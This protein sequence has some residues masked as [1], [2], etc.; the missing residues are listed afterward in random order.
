MSLRAR[1][2]TYRAA[3]ET[4][5][6]ATSSAADFRRKAQFVDYDGLR[7]A[8]ESWRADHPGRPYGHRRD[9]GLNPR[10]HTDDP[11]PRLLPL[12]GGYYGARKGSEPLHVQAGQH[13]GKVL[14]VNDTEFTVPG[15]TVTARL[16][17]L[18]GRPLADEVTARLDLA[19]QA[20]TE[21]TTVTF[22]RELPAA[23][24]LRLTLTDATGRVRSVNDYLRC[25]TPMDLRSVNGL[26]FVRL[27]VRATRAQGP[28]IT[29][30]VRNT[31]TSPAAMVRLALLD[32]A[33][34][35][36]PAVAD[37]NYLWLLPGEERDVTLTPAEGRAESHAE[38][39]ATGSAGRNRLSVAARAYNAPRVCCGTDAVP[40]GCAAR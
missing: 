2:D 5:L 8:C 6:G 28:A 11:T 15:A 7:A 22:A 36:R 26:P 32:E 4:R 21:V 10:P 20:I 13:D 25:R 39:P 40:V 17:A 37:D 9:L 29:A 12:E 23:H 38:G 34:E 31:G 14:V 18:G 3:V 19:G 24:L 1:P 33:G 30:T 35:E 27:E 16:Y